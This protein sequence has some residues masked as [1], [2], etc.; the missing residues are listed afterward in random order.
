MEHGT[1]IVSPI[2]VGYTVM[3]VE[4]RSARPEDWIQIWPFFR[5][6]V[7]AGE[8]YAYS[9]DLSA[10]QAQASWTPGNDGTP[11]LRWTRVR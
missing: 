8:T 2:V 3:L 5:D 9:D 10:E 11:R 1:G 6:I 4:I 7:A